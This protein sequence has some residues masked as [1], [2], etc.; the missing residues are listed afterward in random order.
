MIS[1]VST[2]ARST[3][4]PPPG[5]AGTLMVARM[6]CRSLS[7]MGWAGLAAV[8][9]PSPE[10]GAGLGLVA[11]A[12]A[13]A[14]GAGVA[15]VEEVVEDGVT[16]ADW[17][18]ELDEELL[19]GGPPL[20]SKLARPGPVRAPRP[21]SPP[22]PAGPMS[23]MSWLW[24][25]FPSRL[26]RPP[27]PH[28]TSGKVTITA[29]RRQLVASAPT[30]PQGS[31][32][33]RVVQILVDF[34]AVLLILVRLGLLHPE[35]ESFGPCLKLEHV[36]PPTGALWH[37]LELTVI[38]ED[39]QIIF[40]VTRCPVFPAKVNEGVIRLLNVHKPFPFIWGDGS[41]F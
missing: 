25:M 5:P 39:D 40:H 18:R 7:W 34:P 26:C 12:A 37:A 6:L 31:G 29:Q 13:G 23:C 15:R 27:S 32:H 22:R 38:G 9:A 41:S 11:E 4:W 24:L 10:L 19:A 1:G 8:L 3:C 30:R 14:E 21:P 2:L 33:R 17:L 20:P 16:A 28:S 35:E 36:D